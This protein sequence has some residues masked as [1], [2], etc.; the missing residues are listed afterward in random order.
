MPPRG[1]RGGAAEL[2]ASRMSEEIELTDE[3]RDELEEGDDP[4]P[5]VIVEEP[6]PEPYA[7]YSHIEDE[8]EDEPEPEPVDGLD[9]L[10]RQLDELRGQNEALAKQAERGEAAELAADQ[11]HVVTALNA[12]KGDLGAATA[13]Y[14]AAAA[15]GDWKAAGTAQQKMALAAADVRDYEG[16]LD[17]VK[18]AIER[19][20]KGERR[21]Q[22]QQTAA[23]AD[24]F[25]AAIKDASEPSK[26]WCRKNKADLQ[27]SQARAQ[28]A[29]AGH[30]SALEAGIKADSPEYFAFLDK[31]MGYATVTT[32]PTRQPKPT[33][34]PRVAAPAGAR[35][36]PARGGEITE[37]KLSAAE[38]QIARSMGMTTKEYAANK[39]ELIRNGQDATRQGPRYSAQSAGNRR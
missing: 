17:E 14:E 29:M 31:H 39:R 32:K 13:A 25:E 36:A 16:A 21:A 30:L 12:A 19:F 9:E 28:M 18:T 3:E 22:P 37:V 34:Q 11:A 5:D 4:E 1:R 6:E 10:K 24:P 35:S 33:G 27:K 15:K 8:P 2:L 38:V 23:P 20:R 26:E 7:D